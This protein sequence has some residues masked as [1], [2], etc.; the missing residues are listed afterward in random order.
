MRERYDYLY[1]LDEL[2]PWVARIK[3]VAQDASDTYAL[4]N[5]HNLG[6]ATVNALEIQAFL[7]GGPVN[8]PPLLLETYPELRSIAKQSHGAIPTHG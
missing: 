6:K 4:T 8:V 3:A 5:N 2:E 1:S 7:N